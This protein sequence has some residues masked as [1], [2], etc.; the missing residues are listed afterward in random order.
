MRRADSYGTLLPK[1]NL[2]CF[3]LLLIGGKHPGKITFSF[4]AAPVKGIP[5]PQ[6]AFEGLSPEGVR[7]ADT[8]LAARQV[9]NAPRGTGK[10][11][12][13]AFVCAGGGTLLACRPAG[14]PEQR[15]CPV[16]F[17]R[18]TRGSTEGSACPACPRFTSTQTD[19][20]W[21]TGCVPGGF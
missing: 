13:A 7:E 6:P 20:V 2:G 11:H 10:I 21:L 12:A 16:N 15:V 8:A 4:S 9:N 3:L 19:E 17:R 5:G 18:R 1:I 14:G